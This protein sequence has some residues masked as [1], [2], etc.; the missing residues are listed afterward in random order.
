MSLLISEYIEGSSNNKAIELY[1]NSDSLIDLGANGYSL[2][3]YFNGNDSAGTII[4]LTGTVDSDDVFVIADNDAS[5][6]ILAEADLISNSSFFNG[7]DAIALLE[8]GV[9]IDSIGQIGFDP[10][11]E[12]GSGDVSTQNNTL[13]RNTDITVGDSNPDDTFD[14]SLEWSGFPQDTF[15]DLGSFDGAS[16]GD[17]GD[18]GNSS[19]ITINEVDADTPGSDSAEFI[20]LYDGGAGNSSLDG[21]VA[22][23]YNGN[24]D[25]SY[26]A[27]DLDGFST[28]SNGFFVLGNEAVANV[29]LTFG[30]STLQN[31]A[32]AVALYQGNATDFPNGTA[33]TADGLVDAI[34]YDTSDGDDS[35]LL[36][37]LGQDTQFD[38]DANGDK[39][40]DSNSRLPDGT[41][42]FVAQAATP[43]VSNGQTPPPPV[44]DFI[45]IFD[46]QGAAQVSPLNGSQVSTTGIVTAV[47][48]NGFYLQD[49]AGDGNTATS[50]GIFVFTSSAPGVSVGDALEVAGTVSEFTPGGAS[51]GNLSTTQI[52][53]ASISTL[54]TG[55]ALPDAVI[56]GNGGRIPPTSSIDDDPSSLN[57]DT[58]GIDFF[59]SL[60][61]MLVTAQDAVAIAGT[62]RFGEIFTVVDNGAGATGISDRNTLNISP[63]DF[64]PEKV[65]IDS[66]SDILPDFDFPNVNVGDSLGNVT[67]VVSYGFGNFEVI[68]TQPFNVTSANLTAEVTNLQPGEE[69]LTIAS[70]NVLNLDPNDDDGDTDVADGRYDA[71]AGN[72]IT[73]LNTPDIIG[74]QEVQD[75]NGSVNDSTTA[76]DANL[77]QLVD[78]IA[79]NGGP[80]Y[81]FVDNTFIVDDASGGQPGG[82]IRTA[83]LYNP[84]RVDLVE[85]SVQPIG[86]QAPGSPFNGSRL[87]LVAGFSFNGE[88]ITVIDNHFSSKG[89]SSPIFGVDQPFEDLQED[90]NVNGSLDE[91]Q[92]QAQAVDSFVEGILSENPDA[93][94]VT[95]GDLNEFEFISPV[96]EILGSDLTNLVDTL[97]E[98]ERYSFI[99]QG[100]SQQLDHILV[101]DS[102]LEG[103]EFDIVHVN[104]EFAETPQR[105][106]DHDPV[107]A[108]FN[109]PGG[110]DEVNEIRG[111]RGKDNLVGTDNRDLISG[112]RGQDTL[113]GLNGDDTLNGNRGRDLLIGGND[114]DVLSGGRGRDTLEGSDG[115]DTLIGNR[116]RDLLIGG[117]GNDVLDGGRGKDTFVIASGQGTD[118][119]EDFGNDIIGLAD[120]LSFSDLTFS[121]S[122]IFLGEEV[123][124][125]LSGV[126]ATTLTE[127]DFTVV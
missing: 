108:S 102:L 17:S 65:Q 35:E 99:F 106:S 127:S 39:D 73:N 5:A 29:G 103:A 14:P 82:N 28:D 63:D 77:Q 94:L 66:D 33:V 43:G 50:D 34:V 91:R 2:E 105:A 8:N 80:Q 64:N 113:S 15:N 85:G 41:G 20:E 57:P 126:D 47:D 75:N 1:N 125:T 88:E 96:D 12:W 121:G 89:G 119:I 4:E 21:L 32:D 114:N 49:A 117:N 74:L 93:N 78:A 92:A 60:E 52:S 116:G 112:G 86:D 24:G 42:L 23:L 13:R 61:G 7:D 36:T 19:S 25:S 115:D 37:T 111:G 31:G 9:V 72:I 118:I 6:E 69:Q 26:A 51:T 97:P 11:S 123:L 38:E 87:P 44:D 107:L 83:F 95:L 110:N 98:D 54:S 67:G 79:A 84:A 124:A 40:N 101:S 59:E 68:P 10:G 56:I 109:L 16:G 55:N 45:P 46:I 81:E 120:G 70:Y 53:N 62:N 30:N 22:V 58:D 48:S 104:T 71:I 3:F 27:F 76:A 100:N 122:D 18:G 90:P